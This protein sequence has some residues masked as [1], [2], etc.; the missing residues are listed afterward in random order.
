MNNE[1]TT[2]EIIQ[3]LTEWREKLIKQREYIS[4]KINEVERII[5]ANS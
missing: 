4:E 2:E 3:E 1:K 5:K